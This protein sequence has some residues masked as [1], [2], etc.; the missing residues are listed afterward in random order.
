MHTS[1]VDLLTIEHNN[2]RGKKFDWL[3]K[4]TEDHKKLLANAYMELAKKNTGEDYKKYTRFLKIFPQYFAI[5]V[6]GFYDDP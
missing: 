6:Q 3:M 4:N 1:I 2:E 5:N